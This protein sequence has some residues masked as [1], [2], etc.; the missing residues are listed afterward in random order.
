MKKNQEFD[1]CGVGWLI[2]HYSTLLRGCGAFRALCACISWLSP[3]SHE[4]KFCFVPPKNDQKLLF[5]R[6]NVKIGA[7][8]DPEMAMRPQKRQRLL[9]SGSYH[10]ELGEKVAK[11]LSA[12]ER[13][14]K[15][16]KNIFQ[17]FTTSVIKYRK[18]IY[19]KHP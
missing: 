6:E 14:E 7:I 5:Q 16:T 9:I 1:I 17:K 19:I 15:L 18:S 10:K 13:L 11:T 2:T 4:R 8:E 12:Q 3:L